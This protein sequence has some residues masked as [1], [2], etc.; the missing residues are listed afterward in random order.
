MD[1]KLNCYR[2]TK[3]WS[4]N[5]QI[6]GQSQ[7]CSFCREQIRRLI[8][9]LVR[10]TL[11]L[12]LYGFWVAHVIRL[13]WDHDLQIKIYHIG[14]ISELFCHSIFGVPE[15]KKCYFDVSEVLTLAFDK[16]LHFLKAEIYQKKKSRAT[17]NGKKRQFWTF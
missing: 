16:F 13:L 2:C 14:E 9:L 10:T 17:K 4:G 5:G 1:E 15:V 6:K 12:I 8:I 11:C 7:I 3:L